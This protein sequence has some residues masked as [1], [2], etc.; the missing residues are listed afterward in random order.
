MDKERN[1][2]TKEGFEQESLI[3]QLQVETV[4]TAE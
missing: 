2:K 1:V 3:E 4:Q